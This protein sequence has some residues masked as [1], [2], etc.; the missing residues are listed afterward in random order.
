MAI[1]VRSQGDTVILDIQGYLLLT[2]RDN[3][4]RDVVAECLQGGK[5]Q[6]L[7]NLANVKGIDSSGIGQLVQ[8]LA[9]SR[10]AG[11]QLKL[12][13]LSPFVKRVLTITGLL[14]V[15]ECYDDE[16]SALASF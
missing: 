3:R 4:V 16:A 7:L 12:A 1:A 6:L 9:S 11:A 2:N 8:A 5:L 15:F 14:A 13:N 10:K